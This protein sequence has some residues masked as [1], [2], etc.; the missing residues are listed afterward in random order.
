MHET[1]LEVFPNP[2]D[3]KQQKLHGPSR[4]VHV[5]HSPHRTP[6]RFR[7]AR[8]SRPLRAG[9]HRPLRAAIHT[10]REAAWRRAGLGRYLELE[11]ALRALGDLLVEALLGVVGQLEGDL[12]GPRG[13]GQRQQ[14][15]QRQPPPRPLGLAAPRQ[16]GTARGGRARQDGDRVGRG[17]GGCGEAAAARAEPAGERAAERKHSLCRAPPSGSTTG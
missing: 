11:R 9:T 15:Q 8:H 17:A 3:P 14:Q 16:H 10:L 12:G 13:A 4:Y 5:R 2:N 1:V 7:E 6:A